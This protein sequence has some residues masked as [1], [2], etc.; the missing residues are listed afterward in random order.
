VYNLSPGSVGEVPVI[1]VPRLSAG[2]QAQLTAAYR[3]FLQSKGKDRGALD[4]VVLDVLELPTTFA[5]SL[6]NALDRMQHLSDA[7]L[8]PI[9][10]DADEGNTW[11]E[12]LRLL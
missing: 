8:E 2:Q 12:E 5:A 6:E 10:M 7:V 3:V 1:D 9:A 11:P 4:A